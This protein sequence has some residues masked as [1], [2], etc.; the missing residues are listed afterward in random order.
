MKILSA[1][2]LALALIPSSVRAESI[3]YD[4]EVGS[5]LQQGML[6]MFSPSM[7]TLAAVDYSSSVWVSGAS[8]YFVEPVDSATY[9][10]GA[11]IYLIGTP[12]QFFST[13]GASQVVAYDW[14]TDSGQFGANV[15]FA[16]SLA[17]DSFIGDGYISVQIAPWWTV[18]VP[19]AWEALSGGA[20]GT[21]EFTYTYDTGVGRPSVFTALPEPSSVTLSLVAIGLMTFRRS[22]R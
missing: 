16:G 5:L 22:M 8:Y 11:S 3:T 4:V 21:I 1:V 13:G 15:S 6:P 9:S 19:S 7:G 10:V 17:T 2:A 20:F 12:P 18:D 14:P